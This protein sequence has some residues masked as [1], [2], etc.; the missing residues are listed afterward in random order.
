MISVG[1]EGEGHPCEK[2]ESQ[3]DDDE[4]AKGKTSPTTPG[5]AESPAGRQAKCRFHTVGPLLDILF[6]WNFPF[7]FLSILFF[8]D[9]MSLPQK[10]RHL[11]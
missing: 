1:A 5:P 3:H 4:K 6:F 8:S 9:A 7:F 10:Q 11:D 2:D